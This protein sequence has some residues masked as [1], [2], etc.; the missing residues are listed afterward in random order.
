MRINLIKEDK[1]LGERPKAIKKNKYKEWVNPIYL[2][3]NNQ[4]SGHSLGQVLFNLLNLV[5]GT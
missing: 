2:W 4:V 3:P 1:Y 5:S